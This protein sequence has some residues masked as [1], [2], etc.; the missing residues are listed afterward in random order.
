MALANRIAFHYNMQVAD[1]LYSH[2][3]QLEIYSGYL[4]FGMDPVF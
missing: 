3:A 1:D 2:I 4:N